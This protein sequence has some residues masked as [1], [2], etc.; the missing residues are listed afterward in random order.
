LWCVC[1][2]VHAEEE[3]HLAWITHH[4]GFQWAVGSTGCSLHLMYTI[5]RLVLLQLVVLSCYFS[6]PYQLLVS[7]SLYQGSLARRCS[8]EQ[9]EGRLQ[10]VRRRAVRACGSERSS[11]WCSRPHLV[12]F[13]LAFKSRK[14]DLLHLLCSLEWMLVW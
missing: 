13:S 4:T 1:C 12:G 7:G 14:L 5:P 8:T 2:W 9:A 11:S 10:E 3:P 6:N